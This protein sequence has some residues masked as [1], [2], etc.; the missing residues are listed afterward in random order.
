MTCASV[1]AEPITTVFIDYVGSPAARPLSYQFDGVSDEGVLSI[2]IESFTLLV[3]RLIGGETVPEFIVDASFSLTAQ[4]LTDVSAPPLAAGEFASVQF[5]I[6]DGDGVLLLS[7]NTTSDAN[8]V[9]A[10]AGLQDIMLIAGGLIPIT[11]GSL[12]DDFN[13]AATLGGLGFSIQPGTDSFDRLDVDHNGAVKLNINPIPEPASAVFWSLALVGLR[14]VR[15]RLQ[16]KS[17]RRAG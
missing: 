17:L 7:G 8:V 1:R 11:G 12:A 14:G 4:V 9:Y 13:V 16:R 5:E 2:E 15:A 6:Y 10:E 3:E